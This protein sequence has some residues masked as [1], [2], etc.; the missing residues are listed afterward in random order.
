MI[1]LVEFQESSGVCRQP[2]LPSSS[3][4][5]STVSDQR[6]YRHKAGAEEGVVIRNCSYSEL[7]DDWRLFL[8]SLVGFTMVMTGLLFVLWFMWAFVM[9]A[10]NFDFQELGNVIRGKS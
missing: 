10:G 6:E 1:Q 9:G 3:L 5:N 4:A 7:S 2:D 8:G